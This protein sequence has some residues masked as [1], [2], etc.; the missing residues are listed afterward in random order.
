[1]ATRPVTRGDDIGHSQGLLRDPSPLRPVGH[2]LR[3]R[4]GFVAERDRHHGVPRPASPG[5][6]PRAGEIVQP[7]EG[8]G[9]IVPA[10]RA[11]SLTT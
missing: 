9:A 8:L 6:R 10:M 11:P 3:V 1:M 2:A 5:R 7:G 4:P